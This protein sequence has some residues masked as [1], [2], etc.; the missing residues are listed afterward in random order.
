MRDGRGV[1]IRERE[2]QMRLGAFLSPKE[3]DGFASALSLALHK[4]KARLQP[5]Y[6]AHR[7]EAG[8]LVRDPKRRGQ[9]A[10]SEHGAIA[11]AWCE[12]VRVSR[13][14]M[15]RHVVIANDAAAA[16]G[17]K[18]DAASLCVRR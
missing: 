8:R 12:S 10:V 7:V 4:A 3:C 14:A 9:C 1:L 11:C 16:N 13:S 6:V 2:G 5:Q 15:K 18:A 17:G